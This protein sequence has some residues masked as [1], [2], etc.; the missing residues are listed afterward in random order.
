MS[1]QR[2]PCYLAVGSGEH[3]ST[4]ARLHAIVRGRVQGVFFR[5]HTRHWALD[6]NLGGFVRN[7]ADGAV[8]IVAEG[9]K[10]A[11][12]TLRDRLRKGPAEAWVQEM[13]LQWESP[14]G[15]YWTFEVRN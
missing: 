9:E 5:A 12:E 15:E 4:L 14:T 3:S 11:L 2:L 10:D 13:D 8:E 7:R 1:E 6:L